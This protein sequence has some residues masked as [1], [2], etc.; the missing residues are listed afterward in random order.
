MSA[1][2]LVATPIVLFAI[3]LLLCFVGCDALFGLDEI[4]DPKPP[5]TRYS[6]DTILAEPT[7]V[8]YW[9]LGEAAGTTA[10]DRK[11]GRN[12]TYLSQALPDDP[13]IPSAQAPGTLTLGQPGIVPGDT[14][15][16]LFDPKVPTKCIEVNGG[17]V[18]IPFD[19]ALN[20]IQAD[21]FSIEAWVWV[22]WKAGDTAAV[23]IVMDSLDTAAGVNGYA[24]GASPANTWQ[25]VVGIG[26]DIAVATGPD[27]IFGATS[28]LVLTYDKADST[29][30]LFINGS[31]TSSV[32]TDYQANTQ[33]RLFIG[34]GGPSLPEPRG[35]W[36]GKIQCVAIYT[37]ALEPK[38]IAQH[39][40]FGNGMDVS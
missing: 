31:L 24:L 25:G 1:S 6:D 18:S 30:R 34:V 15:P 32:P 28:H 27:V 38:R 3:V 33:S 22:G 12:G 26:S 16:P 23:R 39:T 29:L 20:P 37:G 21:G 8:A 14:V 9:S 19:P 35:P 11:G 36:V 17:W 7:L 10:V 4:P 40:A 5:F 2:V 13:S